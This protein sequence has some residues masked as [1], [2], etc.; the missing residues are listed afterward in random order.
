MLNKSSGFS[1]L[2]MILAITLGGFIV[3]A[4]MILVLVFSNNYIKSQELEIRDRQQICREKFLK[5]SL[6]D[7]CASKQ[8]GQVEKTLLENGMFWPTND[9]HAF[10]RPQHSFIAGLY[11]HDEK[12]YFLWS[13]SE[14]SKL[15]DRQFERFELFDDVRSVHVMTYDLHANRWTKR[16]FCDKTIRK[17]LGK[18]VICYLRVKRE[19]GAFF[20]PLF[21]I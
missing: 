10:E 19:N 6:M 7:Y 18:N 2:E 4:A 13:K 21:G 8:V 15:S 12:L 14:D 9:L 5:L 11:L 3:T 16:R 1:L 17:Y 20:L